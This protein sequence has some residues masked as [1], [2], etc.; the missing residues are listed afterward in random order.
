MST[1]ASHIRRWIY[2]KPLEIE[3]YELVGSNFKR[4]TI[5][6]GVSN[7]HVIDAVM[8]NEAKT[9]RSRPRSELRGL[10]QFLEDEAK[11]EAKNNY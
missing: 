5:A 2:R 6:N 1:I 3:A 7:G 9:S 11:A 4:T 10:D 8:L